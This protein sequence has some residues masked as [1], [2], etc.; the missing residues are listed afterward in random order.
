MLGI[1]MMKRD[2]VHRNI[3]FAIHHPFPMNLV[4]LPSYFNYYFL[5]LLVER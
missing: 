3:E 5:S 4:F 2:V 1:N